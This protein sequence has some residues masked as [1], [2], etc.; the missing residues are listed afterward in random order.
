[1]PCRLSLCPCDLSASLHDY[2]TGYLLMATALPKGQEGTTKWEE[3][4]LLL[5]LGFA[6]KAQD[7]ALT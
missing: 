3:A 2:K 1:M 4:I 6:P 5:L 7:S